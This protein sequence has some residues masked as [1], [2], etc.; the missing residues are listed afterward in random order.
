MFEPEDRAYRALGNSDPMRVV[1]NF[2]LDKT[3]GEQTL[4]LTK[5][6]ECSSFLLPRQAWLSSF[7]EPDRFLVEQDVNVKSMNLDSLIDS[8]P[9]VDLI[10]LDAQGGE[11]RILQ[12]GSQMLR[13]VLAVE[14]EVEFN[15]IYQQQPLFSDIDR[16]LRDFGFELFDLRRYHWSRG[17]LPSMRRSR[18]QI[19]FG[20]AL[21][22]KSLDVLEAE[23]PEPEALNRLKRFVA[24]L[25][26]YNRNDYALEALERLIRKRETPLP[27]N[28]YDEM[29]ALC[30]TYL[31]PASIPQFRGK[32]RIR[33]FLSDLLKSDEWYSADEEL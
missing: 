2:A 23:P 5:K 6:R 1:H 24:I 25:L 19:I 26:L 21:Y 27:A 16:F 13:K 30:K 32:S 31:K 20:D 28:D 3:P 4:H 9:A 14:V 12:G 22:L 33:S 17:S 15:A 10:K 7:P 18:G 8:T 11:L 29:V